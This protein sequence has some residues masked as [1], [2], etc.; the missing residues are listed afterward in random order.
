MS[1]GSNIRRNASSA[2]ARG[3]TDG[4][5]CLRRK[6]RLF[7]VAMI[8]TVNYLRKNG[9]SYVRGRRSAGVIPANGRGDRVD[10]KDR[11]SVSAEGRGIIDKAVG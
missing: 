5:L 3:G 6:S 7:D 2:C 4:N 8:D 11:K 1:A 10:N 9:V